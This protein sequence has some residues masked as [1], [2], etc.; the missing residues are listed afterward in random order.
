MSESNGSTI[1]GY[2]VQEDLTLLSDFDENGDMVNPDMICKIN[3]LCN[4]CQEVMREVEILHDKVLEKDQRTIERTMDIP[5]HASEPG[6]RQSIGRGCHLCAIFLTTEKFC[7]AASSG[8]PYSTVDNLTSW[9]ALK[10]IKGQVDMRQFRRDKLVG[11][12][13]V[14]YS[15]PGR[16]RGNFPESL[17]ERFSASNA[18][19]ESLLSAS[20]WLGSCLKEHRHQQTYLRP[21]QSPKRL[22]LVG[23]ESKPLLRVVDPP[24][25]TPYLTVSHCWGGHKNLTLTQDT[26]NEL[27]AFF[28][29]QKLPRL[30]RDFVIVT[31]RLGYEYL[32]I[33]S[34]C[35]RQDDKKEVDA[36]IKKMGDI[37]R[38]SMCN[39]AAVSAPNSTASLFTKLVPLGMKNACIKKASS[40]DTSLAIMRGRPFEARKPLYERAW[41][42]Q[43]RVLPPRTLEFTSKGIRHCCP[44]IL[45]RELGDYS[46]D[47]SAEWTQL[48]N[49]KSHGL[50]EYEK[51]DH[52]NLWMRVVQQY[53]GSALT[54]ETDRQAA[55]TGVLTVLSEQ[56]GFLFLHGVCTEYFPYSLLW[57]M[58]EPRNLTECSA[59]TGP[60]WSS[61]FRPSRSW[62][63]VDKDDFINGVVDCLEYRVDVPR[64]TVSFNARCSGT[65]T[66]KSDPVR[67]MD[68]N[69]KMLHVQNLEGSWTDH[70]EHELFDHAYHQEVTLW[71]LMDYYG[72]GP[73][74]VEFVLL[75][76]TV[77]LRHPMIC[78]AYG[79]VLTRV[80][81]KGALWKRLG[82]FELRISKW[83]KKNNRAVSSMMQD[84]L[85]PFQDEREFEIC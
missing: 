73:T 5:F 76:H 80:S 84:I 77:S 70:G 25:H 51:C 38:G 19:K 82:M 28:K 65:R 42:V 79:L 78:Q 4:I 75:C 43:E 71:I 32:W 45:N 61:T 63:G 39:I 6:I 69:S 57:K 83:S 37:Y 24:K 49:S 52:Q 59:F 33:D 64:S 67:D 20:S 8:P 30:W 34:L 47:I 46:A 66:I 7:N 23:T 16:E 53:T 3:V 50:S 85:A 55:L 58:D 27:T 17:E 22:L 15:W 11:G 40:T 1:W 31:R 56:T 54:Y 14:T 44:D 9:V 41:V 74:E 10:K 36:E 68:N 13:V 48:L 62:M 72:F 2:T 81:G 29:D 12:T 35:I 60:S 18:S 26:E 21:P